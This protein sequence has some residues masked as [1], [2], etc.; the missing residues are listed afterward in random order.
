VRLKN[1][2]L[3]IDAGFVNM[4]YAV[5][6]LRVKSFTEA[7]VWST[8]KSQGILVSEDNQRRCAF[9]AERLATIIGATRPRLVVAELPTGGA[10]SAKAA[11]SMGMSFAIV[12]SVCAATGTPLQMIRPLEIKRLVAPNARSV[13]KELVQDYIRARYGDDL[14]PDN[15]RREHVADAMAALDVWRFTHLK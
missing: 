13:S 5:W 3:A 14:L 6:S 15:A 1:T 11:S 7:G 4:G 2:I 9:L 12:C 8:E 10:K